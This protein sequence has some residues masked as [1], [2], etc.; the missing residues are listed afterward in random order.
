MF[1]N[2]DSNLI[3]LIPLEHTGEDAWYWRKE[4]TGR[5]TIKNGYFLLQDSCSNHTSNNFQ[6]WKRLWNLKIPT[7]VKHFLWRASSRCLPTKDQLR[8]RQ[9]NVDSLCVMC[10]TQEET[11]VSTLINCSFA[12]ACWRL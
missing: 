8:A 7:K 2:R 6:F 1:D 3:L 4:K 11:I 9:V 12:Q 5:Y 10:N